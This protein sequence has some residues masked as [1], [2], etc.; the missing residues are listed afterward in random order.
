MINA[1]IRWSDTLLAEIWPMAV[2]H[3]AQLHNTK[4]IYDSLTTKAA[5][6]GF[7]PL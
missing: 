7:S 5:Q 4:M 3:A 1:K 6:K 2:E